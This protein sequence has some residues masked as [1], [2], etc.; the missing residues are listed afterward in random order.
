MPFREEEG[1]GKGGAGGSRHHC[2][3][4]GQGSRDSGDPG[5]CA[6]AKRRFFQKG[7]PQDALVTGLCPEVH[8][9]NPA[10]KSHYTQCIRPDPVVR[11]NS[12]QGRGARD[13]GRRAKRKGHEE[14]ERGRAV[15]KPAVIRPLPPWPLP[16]GCEQEKA[17][18]L[19]RNRRRNGAQGAGKK[20]K[21]ERGC[22]QKSQ[23]GCR[24]TFTTV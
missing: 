13:G 7:S 24:L 10:N 8:E 14:G 23:P 17:P 3:L 15:R 11:A 4:P 21:R 22:A 2:L 18:Y 5:P 19:A 1:F 9:T 12:A 6:P 16:S 20:E